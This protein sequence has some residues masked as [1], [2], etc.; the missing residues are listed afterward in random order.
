MNSENSDPIVVSKAVAKRFSRFAEAD[1]TGV[2]VW[3]ADSEEDWKNVA[4]LRRHGFDRNGRKGS[5]WVD[6]SDFV[7]ETLVLLAAKSHTAPVAT[8][9]L[10]NGIVSG[11]ELEEHI[12][13]DFLI[14]E[15][16]RPLV[17][18]SRLSV[19]KGDSSIS[20]MF[21]LFK[22]AWLWCF[23][24]RLESIVIS[25]P[26]WA[27]AIYQ[28][29]AFR[30]YGSAGEFIHPLLPKVVHSTML[31]P[32]QNAEEVWRQAGVPLCEQ[33]WEREHPDLEFWR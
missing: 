4:M 14:F 19:S 32:I 17:Q 13:L 15:N 10:Q 18:F 25:S 21:A 29:M 2:K 12:N 6:D 5:K 22:S 16:E 27:K 24:N 31:L 30:D 33:I 7:D 1:F 9:K 11:I 28:F 23:I 8:L 26:P 20:I 3:Q